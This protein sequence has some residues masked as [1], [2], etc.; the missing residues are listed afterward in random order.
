MPPVGTRI[1][2]G[3]RGYVVTEAPEMHVEQSADEVNAGSVTI[4]VH[5][6]EA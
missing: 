5:V 6:K 1:V 3:S 2:V 4:R